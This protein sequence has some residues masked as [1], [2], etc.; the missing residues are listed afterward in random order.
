MMRS[1]QRGRLQQ[2]GERSGAGPAM[3]PGRPPSGALPLFADRCPWR[4]IRN[5]VAA[6]EYVLGVPFSASGY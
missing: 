3:N 4:G 2:A 1:R 6:G 5:T